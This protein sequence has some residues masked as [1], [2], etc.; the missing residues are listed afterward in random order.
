MQFMRAFKREASGMSMSPA[1]SEP[2]SP[3]SMRQRG[4][5]DGLGWRPT[6]ALLRPLLGLTFSGN[7]RAAGH[8]AGPGQG[9][10]RRA[11]G[12]R[13]EQGIPKQRQTLHDNRN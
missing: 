8:G 13:R 5:R 7:P 12:A 1:W 11:W 3:G 4:R 10:G 6:A 2:A 9:L